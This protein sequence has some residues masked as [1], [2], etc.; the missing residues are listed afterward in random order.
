M[1]D[2]DHL[3]KRGIPAL[4]VDVV[5]DVPEGLPEDVRGVRNGIPGRVDKEPV[6]IFLPEQRVRFQGIE[7]VRPARRTRRRSVN[8]NDRDLPRRV[9]LKH[10]DSGAKLLHLTTEQPSHLEVP[11]S[12]RLQGVRKRRAQVGLQGN[13]AAANLDRLG[14]AGIEDF[15]PAFKADAF[16]I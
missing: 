3:A 4:R 10:I 9:G 15:Q 7:R 8:E 5:D 11:E 1:A 16:F 14:V 6:L 2:E 12:R 13:I